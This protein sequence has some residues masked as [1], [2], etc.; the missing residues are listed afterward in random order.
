MKKTKIISI[1]VAMLAVVALGVFMGKYM[2][3]LMEATNTQT[4]NPAVTSNTASPTVK[5]LY[6]DSQ[7][8]NSQEVTENNVQEQ[9][10][11]PVTSTQTQ[12]DTSKAES[13]SATVSNEAVASVAQET[14]EPENNSATGFS[15]TG[16]KWFAYANTNI[17][18]RA[19]A[20]V[21]SKLLF[22][23][24]KGSK[25]TVKEKKDGWT[26]VQWDYRKLTGWTKDD[27][28]IQGPA[29]VVST[30]VNSTKMENIDK[31][32][33]KKASVEKTAEQ[34]KVIYATAKPALASETVITYTNGKNLPQKGTISASEGANIRAKADTKSERLIRLPKGTIVGIKSVKKIGK[35][36]WFEIT[37]SNGAK[38]G[39]TREDNLRF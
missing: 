30:A 33:L 12:E 17:N 8:A 36:N 26:Y 6:K 4:T 13:V 22:K 32:A 38:S 39:W 18:C 24:N 11:T 21:K 5:I 10:V 29:A 19:S 2:F 25:G 1:A 14:K 23:M 20:D 34:K 7:P 35:H 9:Q 37:Y 3:K 15:P 27:F 28:L 31:E 16:P